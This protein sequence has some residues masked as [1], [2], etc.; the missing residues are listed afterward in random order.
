[1]K[2]DARSGRPSTAR[3]DENVESVRL[4]TEDCCT[5]LQMIADRLNIGKETVRWIVTEDLG[6]KKDLHE[7]CSSCLDHR[8]EHVVYCQDLLLM[9]ED[10][11]FGENIITG[12]KTWCFAYDPA[13][14]RQ[15]AEWVGQ[16]SPKTK[17]PRFQKSRV[18]V[19]PPPAEGV[20]HREFVPEGQK[21]NAEFYVDV[22]SD[23][24]I[25]RVD[26]LESPNSKPV[27]GSF[28]TITRHLITLQW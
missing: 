24:L 10:E 2:D 27:S 16:N 18:Q 9:G 17:K 19:S 26:E 1:M 6:K 25:R 7:I 5:T 12:D 15:S 28:F 22:V 21:V 14:K 3:T 11:R 8:A 20:I 23:R 4:L 13:T